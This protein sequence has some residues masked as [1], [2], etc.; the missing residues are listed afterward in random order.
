MTLDAGWSA[1]REARW[2]AAAACFEEAGET[3][4]GLEGLSWAAW[5]RDD[6]ETV[7]D[8]RERAYRL[9]R[10]RG[11]AA[12]AA[13]MA[14]WLACDQLDF[15]G[16]PAVAGGWL[17]RAHRLLHPLEPGPEHGW[18][19]FFEGYMAGDTETALER[20]ARAAELGRRLGVPDLE[21]LGLALEGGTLVE[22]ARIQEGMRCLDEATALALEG[23]AAIPISG[24]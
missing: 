10:K 22:C 8:A 15:L 12:G 23:E 21:M 3:P 14:T 20:A 9:Y 13:R 19:A 16:A 5:W 1:L 11:D 24:A 18:L 4:E 6:A 2:E 7:F 17:A